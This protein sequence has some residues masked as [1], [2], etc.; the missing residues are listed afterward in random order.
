MKARFNKDKV[1]ENIIK[2]NLEKQFVECCK[3][4]VKADSSN[5][6]GIRCEK[7]ETKANLDKMFGNQLGLIF[8]FGNF[9]NSQNS[10][11]LISKTISS[12]T[13]QAKSNNISVIINTNLN[14]LD[15]LYA[16]NGN[17][18]TTIVKEM[19]AFNWLPHQFVPKDD[20]A[21]EFYKHQITYSYLDKP[22]YPEVS[23]HYRRELGWDPIKLL[24]DETNFIASLN[25]IKEN[26]KKKK[27]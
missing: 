5:A 9:E 15:T 24:K 4:T 23:D 6:V 22:L 21:Y 13:D 16:S 1:V 3:N 27:K 14:Y 7:C 11:Q 26:L 25:H 18:I 12:S 20:P 19:M 2:M 8:Y 17:D 10:I